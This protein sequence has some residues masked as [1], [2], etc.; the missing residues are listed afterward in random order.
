MEFVQD[1]FSVFFF[2]SSES[3]L[4]CINGVT[5]RAT[6]EGWD[7]L[8][9]LSSARAVPFSGKGTGNRVPWLLG[10]QLDQNPEGIS[11]E[12]SHP[13]FPLD[14]SLSVQNRSRKHH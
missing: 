4:V 11:E 9:D 8:L 5:F 12:L 1:F 10:A 6:V 3:I 7:S 13:L 14:V 2:N